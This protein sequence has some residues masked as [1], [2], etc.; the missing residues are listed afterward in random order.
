MAAFADP[1]VVEGLWRE[2]TESEATQVLNL[3]AFASGL[4]RA[5]VLDVDDRITDG[6]LDGEFV[7][8]ITALMVIRALKNP[9]AHRAE[10]IDDF[11][12]EIDAAQ[13]TGSVYLSD[14]EL[15]VLRG[16]RARSFTIA[17]ARSAPTFDEL[18]RAAAFRR[19]W[20]C[21]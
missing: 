5:Q 19:E 20:A 17:T 12:Y 8:Q 7:G 18:E 9:D 10:S 13:A 21:R 14:D 4:I 1:D 2:L 15:K 6:R 3:L 11:S 16:R